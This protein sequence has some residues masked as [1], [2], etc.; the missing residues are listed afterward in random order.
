MISLMKTTALWFKAYSEE[1]RLRILALLGAGELCVC[2]LMA[3]LEL[4]QSTVS[5]HLAYLR[6]AGLVEGRRQDAWVYYRLLAPPGELGACLAA[7]PAL[8]AR[9]DDGARDLARLRAYQAEQGAARCR[10]E[11]SEPLE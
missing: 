3:V 8:L 4:P 10:P 6:N 5:R 1:I 11:P 7:L 9:S 2:D